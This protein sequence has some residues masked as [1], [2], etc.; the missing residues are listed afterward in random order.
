MPTSIIARK[1][2]GYELTADE[3]RFIVQ[4]IVDDSIPDYQ[5]SAWAMAVLCRGMSV[6]E[7]ATLTDCMLSSGRR[8][9]R[10]TERLRVDKHSTGGLGDKVSLILAPLLACVGLDVPMLSGRGLGITGGTLDKL[11][12]YPGF[13]CNLDETEIERQLQNIG[14]VITGT[15]EHIA[16]ADRKLYLLRDV[17]ATVPS[18]GL[19]TGSIMS[20]KLA[21]NLDAL[22]LDVKFGSGAFMQ[23][24]EDAQRLMKSLVETGQ[25]M[26]LTTRA[27]LSDMNQPLGRMVGNACEANEAVIVLQGG[28]P[29]DVRTLTLRLGAELCLAVGLHDSLEESQAALARHLDSGEAFERFQQM[30]ACQGGLFQAQ[31]PLA[32]GAEVAAPTSGWISSVDGQLLGHA[33]IEM[34]GGRQRKDSAIDHSVGLEMLV[35]IGDSVEAGQPLCRIFAHN[36]TDRGLASAMISQALQIS[37]QPVEPLSLLPAAEFNKFP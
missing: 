15:T 2:D 28:G 6:A 17:T 22:V 25:R 24:F 18:I 26:G 5:L 31:L 37:S 29:S 11:E 35:R 7:I 19:I 27:V 16:P 20:K 4:G 34:G 3:I 8:L 13:R 10:S 23:E 32:P 12:A 36:E 1:R 9:R 33:V 30:I 21:A 14:C